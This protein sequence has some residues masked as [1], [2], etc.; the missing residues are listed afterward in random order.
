MLFEPHAHMQLLRAGRIV[1]RAR[2]CCLIWAARHPFIFLCRDRT[3]IPSGTLSVERLSDLNK[4][5][6][7]LEEYRQVQGAANN[8]G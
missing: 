8:P 1:G 6:L 2:A 5:S 4:A 3:L 7:T